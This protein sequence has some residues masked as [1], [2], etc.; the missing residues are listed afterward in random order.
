MA[1]KPATVKARIKFIFI[2]IPWAQVARMQMLPLK[3]PS[4]YNF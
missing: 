3:V 2:A 1:T 4:R